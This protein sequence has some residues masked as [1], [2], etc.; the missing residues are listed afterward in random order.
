VS[1]VHKG[2]DPRFEWTPARPPVLINGVNQWLERFCMQ[3]GF[4]YVNYFEALRN[5]AGMLTD[6]LSDDGLHPNGKG[7]RIMAPLLDEA[8]TPKRA[9]PPPPPVPQVK[10]NKGK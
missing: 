4:T 9:P 8:V 2:V 1:D 5:E 6:D 10:P 7:Y 3:R